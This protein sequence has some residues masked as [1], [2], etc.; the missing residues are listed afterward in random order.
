MTSFRAPRA[1]LALAIAAGF[2]ACLPA[3][4]EPGAGGTGPQT[5]DLCPTEAAHQVL[6]DESGQALADAHAVHVPTTREQKVLATWWLFLLAANETGALDPALAVPELYAEV[7]KIAARYPGFTEV[8]GTEVPQAE[9][10]LITGPES[11]VCGERCIP[12]ASLLKH[13]MAQLVKYLAGKTVT[14]VK[15]LFQDLS[16]L[17]KGIQGAKDLG[18]NVADVIDAEMS[19][20]SALATLEAVAG[21]VM[22]AGAIAAAAVLLG[23]TSGVVA[24]IAAVGAAVATFVIP[25]KIGSELAKV[26]SLV[27]QCRA[28]Q[29]ECSTCHCAVEVIDYDLGGATECVEWAGP[30]ETSFCFTL[31]GSP[32]E[33]CTCDDA[34]TLAFNDCATLLSF[35]P[36]PTGADYEKC[37]SDSGGMLSSKSSAP[38]LCPCQPPE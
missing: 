34:V 32:N 20:A 10:A 33:C 29:A 28:F 19:D 1:W 22:S 23:S 17:S 26:W 16:K 35:E 14:P 24:G 31:P 8:C 9:S 4:E 27:K 30:G 21:L 2:G 12:S 6:S 11:F 36:D 3:G 15:T 38:P 13:S 18:K 5:P 7:A 37:C 25:I